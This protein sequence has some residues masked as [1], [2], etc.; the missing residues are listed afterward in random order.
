MKNMN[1]KEALEIIAKGEDTAKIA[2]IR[3]FARI[4]V[5]T[6]TLKKVV[7]SST[8][9]TTTTKKETVKEVKKTTIVE[10]EVKKEVVIVDITPI[11]KPSDRFDIEC[12]MN[13]REYVL[14]RG[15]KPSLRDYFKAV[16]YYESRA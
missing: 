10:E 16:E 4:N 9:V 1:L 14:E 6:R 13:Y 11:D 3:E 8:T 12:Y 2:E 5:E 7:N 15:G